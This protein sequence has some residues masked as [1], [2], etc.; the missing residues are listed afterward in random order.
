MSYFLNKFDATLLDVRTRQGRRMWRMDAPL[1][2]YST[3]L[4]RVITVPAGFITDL[5]SAP[6]W[7][8]V[9]WLVGDLVQEPA[10]LHDFCYSTGL[11]PRDVC[12]ALLMEAAIATGTP[13]WQASLIW[14]GVRIG[15]AGSYGNQYTATR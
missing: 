8:V 13:T 12:D 1:S 6:R 10:V 2:Y 9:Y 3:K 14:A 4:G 7:P 11:F 15:G 5:E